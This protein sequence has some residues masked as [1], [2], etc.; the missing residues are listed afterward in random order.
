M[1]QGGTSISSVN[2][3]LKV[4]RKRLLLRLVIEYL[5]GHREILWAVEGRSLEL[6][7]VNTYFD[8]KCKMD[9]TLE[10]KG[11]VDF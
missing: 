7:C 2:G 4:K 11:L 3:I 6:C 5:D 10:Y 9:I 8:R 1:L